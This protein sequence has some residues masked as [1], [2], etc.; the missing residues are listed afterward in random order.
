RSRL[1]TGRRK[2][3]VAEGAVA[4]A[5]AVAVGE[6]PVAEAAAGAA[7]AEAAVAEGAAAAAVAEGAGD[8]ADPGLLRAGAGSGGQFFGALLDVRVL[9]AAAIG[10]GPCGC[11]GGEHDGAGPLGQGAE[12]GL[13]KLP[14]VGVS[15][16]GR[17]LYRAEE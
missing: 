3:P 11:R 16:G 1:G 10:Q 7:V 15:H 13:Q 4:E 14:S 12:E 6:A 5:A 17:P 9:A 8:E 2:S